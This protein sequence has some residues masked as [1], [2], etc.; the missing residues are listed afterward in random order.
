MATRVGT[1][2]CYIHARKGIGGGRIG[3]VDAEGA[4]HAGRKLPAA[5]YRAFAG[6]IAE[7]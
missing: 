4:Q 1:N 3:V 6:V 5:R 2:C 7:I